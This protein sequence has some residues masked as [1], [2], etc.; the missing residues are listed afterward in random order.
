[1]QQ[2]EILVIV[3]DIEV[4]EIGGVK[5]ILILVFLLLKKYDR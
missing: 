2:I 3:L 5:L 1:M 4:I